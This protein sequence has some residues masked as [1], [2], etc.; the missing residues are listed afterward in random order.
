MDLGYIGYLVLYW[1]GIHRIHGIPG[2]GSGAYRMPRNWCVSLVRCVSL[3]PT[4]ACDSGGPTNSGW[5]HNATYQ[6]NA[7]LSWH[8]V[9]CRN[10]QNQSLEFD[11][12]YEFQSNI[13]PI[14]L[15]TGSNRCPKRL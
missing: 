3:P 10:H 12:F 4:G 15:Y 1:T 11:E 14:S 13:G 7:T 8:Y 9:S 6:H 2:S 5:K